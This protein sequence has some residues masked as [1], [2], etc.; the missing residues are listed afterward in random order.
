MATSFAAVIFRTGQV[1]ERELSHGFAVSLAGWE[2]PAP[3]LTVAEIRGLPGWS[4]AFYR[5]GATGAAGYEELD[6]AS[7]LFEDELPPGLC[8]RDAAAGRAPVVYALV[9]SD[10][11]T[12]D[13]AWRFAERA[14][15]RR[16]VR[17]G[18]DGLEAGV[19]TLDASE[20]RPVDAEDDEAALAQDRGST[21]LSR[22][23]GRPVIPALVGA[24]F[25]A[26]RRVEVRLFAPDPASIEQQVHRLN[27]VLGR[28]DGRGAFTPPPSVAG[29]APPPAFAAFVR[30][31]DW[32]D[33]GD[34]G[35]LYRELS[36][37]AVE[38]TLRFL[39]A[40]DLAKRDAD[41][42]WAPAA[43]AG[44]FPVA[45]LATGALGAG[46]GK[47]ERTLALAPDGDQLSLVDGAGRIAPAGPTFAELLAY[48][49]LGWKKRD[50]VEEDLI[51]A[52]MLRARVR[53]SGAGP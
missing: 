10:E 44:L 21:F 53:T 15:E 41:P 20:V 30:A 31:Y 38:G 25:E 49:S 19:E 26:D 35:D 32:A 17:E 47:G 36:I 48:L 40:S 12:L 42:A 45:T 52:L 22:E 6:H 39:R 43:R 18:E 34:P 13:D 7:E 37:G 23:L 14:I 29:V 4:A 11:T 50:E 33:P 27:R 28:T 46:S 9:F 1:T 2:A 3:S 5:S 24:L 51:G 8:V 16:F